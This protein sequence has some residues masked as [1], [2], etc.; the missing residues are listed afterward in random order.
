MIVVRGLFASSCVI[1]WTRLYQSLA[2]NL[3]AGVLTLYGAVLVT[4]DGDMG[5]G[6][7]TTEMDG[8][9]LPQNCSQNIR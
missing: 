8:L 9:L 1:K 2:F 4:G 3:H 7:N 5:S 6:S